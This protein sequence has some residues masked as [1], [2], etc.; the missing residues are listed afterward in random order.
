MVSS[1]CDPDIM[2]GDVQEIEIMADMEAEEENEFNDSDDTWKSLKPCS[3][4]LP[5]EDIMAKVVQDNSVEVSNGTDR[6]YRSCDTLKIDGFPKAPDD[7]RRSYAWAM[8]MRS[9]MTYGFGRLCERGRTHWSSD[10]ITCAGNPSISNLVSR[11]MIALR[12]RKRQNGEDV[13]MSSRAITSQD[14]RE[15][16]EFNEKVYGQETIAVPNSS[17]KQW[18]RERTRRLVHAIITLSFVCLLRADEALNLRME[19]IDI[20]GPKCLSITLQKRKTNQFGGTKPFVLWLFPENES[21]ICPIRALAQWISCSGI[22]SGYIFHPGKSLEF[23]DCENML[24]DIGKDPSVYGT[25]S[26]RRGGCQWLSREK[27]WRIPRICDWGGWSSD[28][29]GHLTIF[30]YL[31]SWNDDPHEAREDFFNPSKVPTTHCPHCGR[32]CSC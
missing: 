2:C 3:S 21:H 19:D 11:Y 23:S 28:P 16:W 4:E 8:K 17:E 13:P 24:I 12:R 15:M 6:E 31:L 14:I 7:Y 22:N 18:G 26:L 32:A 9:S 1:I 30:R 25:H 27:R 5:D 10:G 20:R 29:T